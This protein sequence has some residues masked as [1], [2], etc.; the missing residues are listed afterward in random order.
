MRRHAVRSF[1]AVLWV[2]ALLAANDAMGQTQ[3]KPKPV[4]PPV[5]ATVPAAQPQLPPPPAAVQVQPAPQ[6]ETPPDLGVPP[7]PNMQFIESYN[8]GAGQRYYLFGTAAGF[9]DVVAYYKSVLKQRGELV[10]DAPTATYQFDI[11]RFV[12]E[13]MAFPPSVTVKDYTG[14]G[15][16]GYPNP[17]PGAEPARFKTIIQIVPVLPTAAAPVRR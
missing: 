8:A 12:E 9:A 16:Q 15:L 3:S 17:K 7:Y 5:K 11:G 1:A 10:F 6:A 4:A 13:T 2:G 14:P